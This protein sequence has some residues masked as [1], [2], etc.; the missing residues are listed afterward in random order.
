MTVI[1]LT[2]RRVGKL[3]R[4]QRETNE[5]L[6]GIDGRLEGIEDSL[7]RVVTV[8][9]VHTRHFERLEDALLGIS[10]RM[11]RLVS[12][13]ARGRTRDLVRLASIERRLDRLS[14]RRPRR[15]KR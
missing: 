4:A 2:T 11:D 8:L 6:A 3:E 1:D 7:G 5:R 10:S 14:K 15:A 9:E 12:A 13:I